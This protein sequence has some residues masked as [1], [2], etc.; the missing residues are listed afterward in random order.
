MSVIDVPETVER[1][2]DTH[3]D[4]NLLPVGRPGWRLCCQ[5]FVDTERR[6]ARVL[7]VFRRAGCGGQQ[8]GDVVRQ[9]N[10]AR[11]GQFVDGW[12]Q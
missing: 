5:F 7:R 4:G 8:I 3:R 10:W 2:S 11:S 6:Q 12:E 9:W 1:Q